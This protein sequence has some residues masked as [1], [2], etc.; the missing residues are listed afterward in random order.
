MALSYGKRELDES[1]WMKTAELDERRKG[2]VPLVVPQKLQQ[3]A[4]MQRRKGQA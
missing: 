4:E 2:R 1:S 3:E